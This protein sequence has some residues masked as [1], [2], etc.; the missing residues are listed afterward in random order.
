MTFNP[1]IHHR[2]SIRLKEYDYSRAGA[3]F[4]TVCAWQRECLFGEIKNGDMFLNEYGRIVH[5]HWNAITG[6][7]DNVETDE[8]IVMPNHT[9]GIVILNNTRRGGV[10]PPVPSPVPLVLPVPNKTIDIKTKEGGETPPLRRHTLGQVMAYF[11]YQ[12][13][14]AINQVRTTPGVPVWQRN[15]YKHILRDERELHAVREYIRYNPLK[16]DEDEENPGNDIPW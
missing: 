15:Y 8:F 5:E 12:S 2:R 9:H 16:W 6:Y 1:E 14:K 4:V 11:K 7:F 10:S 3:Y 13:A